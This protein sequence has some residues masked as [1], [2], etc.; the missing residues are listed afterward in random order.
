M[1]VSNGRLTVV[2]RT[3]DDVFLTDDDD[4]GDDVDDDASAMRRQDQG[5]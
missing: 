4:D 3:F 5:C 1:H 2:G